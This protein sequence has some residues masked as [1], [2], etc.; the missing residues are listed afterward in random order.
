MKASNMAARIYSPKSLCVI[1]II[2]IYCLRSSFCSQKATTFCTSGDCW[3]RDNDNEKT[4]SRKK[5]SLTFPEG[6][7][8]QL[9]C[10]LPFHSCVK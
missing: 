10:L 3:N 7:S 1:T 8:L 4:L 2:L 5:R 9:G 6:S